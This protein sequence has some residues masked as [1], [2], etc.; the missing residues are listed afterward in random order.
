ML[1]ISEFRFQIYA[2]KGG[3][4]LSLKFYIVCANVFDWLYAALIKFKIMNER[5]V[6][7]VK[8]E[9]KQRQTCLG[10]EIYFSASFS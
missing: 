9:R 7:N 10:F 2:D 8:G 1:H 6:I 3:F 5:H 4:P